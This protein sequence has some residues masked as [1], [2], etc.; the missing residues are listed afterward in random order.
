MHA[1]VIYFML[2]IGLKMI[3]CGSKHAAMQ[4]KQ[5]TVILTNRCVEGNYVLISNLF[6]VLT[7]RRGEPVQITG[8]RRSG[9]GPRAPYVAYAFVF[10]GSI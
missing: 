3:Y 5:L 7:R 8:A 4:Y 9:R 10:L 2:H 1:V 6:S